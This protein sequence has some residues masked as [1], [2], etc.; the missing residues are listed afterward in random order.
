MSVACAAHVQEVIAFPVDAYGSSVKGEDRV[1]RSPVVARR[2]LG[3]ALKGLR[4]DAH[5][6]LDAA[7]K[8]LDCS[9]S[10]ISRLENG[11]GVPRQRDVRDLI[12]LYGSDAASRQ[13]EL[14]QL[15][16]EGSG[17]GGGLITDYRDV[18]DGD[19]IS[20]DA[21][22]YMALEQD[23][24]VISSFEADFVPGL[25]QTAAYT[26]ALIRLFD[27]NLTS[28]QRRRL[29]DLRQERQKVLGGRE[30]GQDEGLTLSVVVAEQALLRGIGGPQVMREQLSALVQSL[31]GGLDHVNFQVA[32]SS[33]VSAEVMGG[34]FSVLE[35]AD[36]RDQDVVYLE[37]R[38]SATYLESDEHVERYKAVFASLAADSLSP[39]KSISLV[40]DIARD[41]T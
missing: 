10:K 18:F 9:T 37:G 12:E 31:S 25:L 38:V 7:A 8:A 21:Q 23:A 33:L 26:D 24:R 11:K 2:R 6:K 27:P 22:R 34:P 36:G 3:A 19:L 28:D 30:A 1:S 15:V 5:L 41:L 13:D 20:D 39:E 40:E 17:D 29:V 16:A 35:F 4:L 14:M 32:P